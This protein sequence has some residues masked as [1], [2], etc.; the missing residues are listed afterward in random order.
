MRHGPRGNVEVL[1]LTMV[2]MLQN[3]SLATAMHDVIVAL[4]STQIIDDFELTIK[5]PYQYNSIILRGV[6]VLVS[7]F[8]TDMDN[9]EHCDEGFHHV[10]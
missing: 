4:E 1:P 9:S 2:N 5:I 8:D 6:D 10:E 7:D 3:M